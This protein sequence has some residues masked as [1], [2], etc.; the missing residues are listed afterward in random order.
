MPVVKEKSYFSTWTRRVGSPAGCAQFAGRGRSPHVPGSA[1]KR[2]SPYSFREFPGLMFEV[3]C[4][5]NS[6]TG[7]V[8]R[9][10]FA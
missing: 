7:G 4:E 8:G 2:P 9:G 10:Y 5:V 3:Q 1:S 6:L